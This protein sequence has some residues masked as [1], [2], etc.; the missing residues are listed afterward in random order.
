MS[1]EK[2][3]NI[4]NDTVT[5]YNFECLHQKHVFLDLDETLISGKACDDEIDFEKDKEQLVK[6]KFHNMDDLYLI[7]ERPGVQKFLTELFNNYTVSVWTA[8]SK[9]YALFI[10]ENV[11]LNNPPGTPERQLKYA[12]WHDHG[13]VSKKIYEKKPKKLSLLWDIFKLPG[14]DRYNT[15]IID[16]YDK[17][18]S[19]Q[20]DNAIRIAEF[21]CLKKEHENDNELEFMLDTINDKMKTL[22]SK[23]PKLSFENNELDKI[24]QRTMLNKLCK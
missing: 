14:I 20:P 7:S 21:D 16:D 3:S 22:K 23:R 19:C 17:V 12:F 6:F 10:I 8:A 13:S 11:V 5:K 18:T 1:G 15:I 4:I 9:D 2:S 24:Q